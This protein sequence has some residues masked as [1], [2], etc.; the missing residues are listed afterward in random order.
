[1]RVR[2]ISTF[3]K[4]VIL[5]YRFV[6]FDASFT[7]L[8]PGLVKVFFH[9]SIMDTIYIYVSSSINDIN[10]VTIDIYLD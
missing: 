8:S 10:H 2:F 4:V 6:S 3:L 9:D 1:M 7:F 5:A